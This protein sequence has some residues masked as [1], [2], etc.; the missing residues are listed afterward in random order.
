MQK[1]TEE[2]QKAEQHPSK[3]TKEKNTENPHT[4]PCAVYVEVEVNYLMVP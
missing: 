3:A 1:K 2:K 4:F